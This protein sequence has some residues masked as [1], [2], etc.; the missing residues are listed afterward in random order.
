MCNGEYTRNLTELRGLGVEV[1]YGG[2]AAAAL[3]GG[4]RKEADV[5]MLQRGLINS[6]DCIKY[7]NKSAVMLQK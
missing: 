1:V 6:C 2:G 3:D 7:G 5:E 4:E